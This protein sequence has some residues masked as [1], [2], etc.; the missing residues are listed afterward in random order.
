MTTAS[1]LLMSVLD[2]FSKV[3]G[4]QIV[5]I[6]TNEDETVTLKTN[7]TNT[8]VVGMCEYAKAAAMESIL[9]S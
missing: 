9:K 4:K 6:Y 1:E 7:T 5:I 3:E 2:D 8:H